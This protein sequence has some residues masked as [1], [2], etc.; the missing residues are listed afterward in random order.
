MLLI[1]DNQS[2]YIK[3]FKQDV[4]I[5][6]DIPYLVVD[7]NEPIDFTKADNVSGLVLSGGK[8]NPYSPLNLTADFLALTYFDVP[9]IG[10]CLGHEIIAVQYKAR[11]K[12]L[13]EA[14][15]RVS[16]IEVTQPDDP[17]FEGLNST[18]FRIQKKHQWRVVGLAPPLVSLA[19]SPV[20][21]N[22]VIRHSE[23]PI[24]GF[25]G[26]PE[27]TTDDGRRVMENFLGMCGFSEHLDQS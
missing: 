22:E 20:T 19:S 5:E 9:T 25:Q 11:I 14:Q 16:T 27:V 3:R 17:I 18:Q 2:S 21:T 4:L 23:K 26:H 12:R 1:I 24:Y 15:R 13:K 6:Y 8:G 7:H 10:F